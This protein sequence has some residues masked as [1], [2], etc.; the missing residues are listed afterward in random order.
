MYMYMYSFGCPISPVN[1]AG[2]CQLLRDFPTTLEDPYPLAA[3]WAH[4]LSVAA[5]EMAICTLNATSTGIERLL[6]LEAATSGQCLVFC[7]RRKWTLS[8]WV[9]HIRSTR[10]S[11]THS[12]KRV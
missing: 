2:T 7:L 9:P 1:V 5:L 8:V 6:G 10:N 11:S 3:V 12:Y 4:F